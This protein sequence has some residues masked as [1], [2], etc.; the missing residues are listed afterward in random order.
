[1]AAAARALDNERAD[2][3]E[4]PQAEPDERNDASE[5]AG[6]GGPPPWAGGP[7]PWAGSP[8]LAGRG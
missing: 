1:V 8:A 4:R 5:P 7:P 6:R 3:A 2:D